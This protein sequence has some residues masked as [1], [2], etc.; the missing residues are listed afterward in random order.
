MT[1][2]AIELCNFALSRIGVHSI[3]SFNSPSAESR[4]AYN[5][6]PGTRDSLLVSNQWSFA[7]RYKN[8][9]KRKEQLNIEK[10][11]FAIP[12]DCMII[13]SCQRYINGSNIK[14]TIQD[15]SLICSSSRCYLKYIARTEEDSFPEHFKD[16]LRAKLVALFSLSLGNN[17]QYNLLSQEADK[18]MQNARRIE[19]LQVGAPVFEDF[20]LLDS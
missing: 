14:F 3:Q 17:N 4:I 8:L 2:I 10:T 12:A 5:I 18:A 9:L 19:T 15:N 16:A 7:T 13:V 6:Y 11:S 1:N 20:S